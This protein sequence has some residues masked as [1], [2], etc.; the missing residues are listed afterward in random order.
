MSLKPFSRGFT[1][2]EIMLVIVIMSISIVYFASVLKRRTQDIT[3]DATV[4]AM[5]RWLQAG[6]AYY[7]QNKDFTTNTY[8]WPASLV[9]LSPTFLPPEAV[10]SPWHTQ[11]GGAVRLCQGRTEYR[12]INIAPGDLFWGVSIRAPNSKIAQQIA[13]RLPSAKVDG[14][15]V[16]AYTPAPTTSIQQP[17]QGLLIK[18]ISRVKVG[19]L[20]LPVVDIVSDPNTSGTRIAPP[21]TCPPGWKA[22]WQPALAELHQYQMSKQIYVMTVLKNENAELKPTAPGDDRVYI[23]LN[24]TSGGF[25]PYGAFDSYCGAALI[26]TFCVPPNYCNGNVSSPTAGPCPVVKPPKNEC[27]D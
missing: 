10:C 4:T 6:S 19:T 5:Q 27:T 11:Q 16:T 13:A 23:F 14:R 15:E 2:L 7:L 24:M 22:D 9:D 12:A 17:T 25:T 1:L 8:R 18:G 21:T 20:C 3:I 26:V